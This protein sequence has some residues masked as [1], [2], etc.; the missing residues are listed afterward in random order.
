ML[1]MWRWFQSTWLVYG[2]VWLLLSSVFLAHYAWEKQAVYGDG[3]GYFAFLHSWYFDA[4]W[5]FTNEYQHLWTPT[6][7]NLEAPAS[8]DTVQIVTADPQGRARNY[9]LPGTALLWLP[10]YLIADAL[11]LGWNATSGALPRQG[12]SDVYQL[13]VG[14]TAVT[15]A[16]MAVWWWEK[17][18]RLFFDSRV[19]RITALSLLFGSHLLYYAGY[20]VI[21]SHPA[22]VMVSAWIWWKLLKLVR[23]NWQATSLW[24]ESVLLG[25]ASGLATLVRPQDGLVF[26]F[27]ILTL[28]L[29][30]HRQRLTHY[31]TA[32]AVSLSGAAFLVSLLPG[33]YHLSTQ[34]TQ[35]SEHQYVF[36]LLENL[37]QDNLN[38]LG[39]FFDWQTGLFTRAPI[40]VLSL[41]GVWLARQRPHLKLSL[42]LTGG[43][44]IWQWLVITLHGG[45]SAAAFGGRM[46]LSSLPFFAI[47]LAA[48]AE[49]QY[50][51]NRWLIPMAVVATTGL[52]VISIIQ[53]ILQ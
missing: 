48:V 19:S 1:A 28:L 33:I 8:T 9:F 38:W 26:G 52:N 5:E 7:N 4:D 36:G 51:N 46:Y 11:V 16:V 20:D 27:G 44:F 42:L 21:N 47:L 34:F 14:L 37:H 13:A 49:W 25:V 6:N 53:F 40:L 23:S 29:G 10:A 12:Y 30:W 2:L 39:S 32:L 17:L 31:Q 43:F 18:L 45:W 24:R 35:A 15:F 41:V 3:I 50:D 22:S